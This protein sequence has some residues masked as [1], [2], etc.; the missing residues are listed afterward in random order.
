LVSVLL[1]AGALLAPGRAPAASVV[2]IP[3]AD[4]ARAADVV[5]LGTVQ[6]TRVHRDGGATYTVVEV[7]AREIL[8]GTEPPGT[9]RVRQV[10]GL[11]GD[12]GSI[13]A[14][15]ATFVPGECVVLFLERH[16]GE[17]RLLGEAQGKFRVS[18]E[19]P[20]TA[21]T[22]SRIDPDTGR[23]LDQIPLARVRELLA[24]P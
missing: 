24:R 12:G 23:V 6:G 5:V 9:V 1:A 19:P 2:P 21:W 20:A 10:G 8:K 13:V 22:A 11:I 16:G 3:V 14:G 15:A 7:R 4:L 17:L 18:R